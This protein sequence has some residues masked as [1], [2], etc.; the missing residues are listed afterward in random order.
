MS[1]GLGGNMS[2]SHSGKIANESGALTE[3]LRVRA[4]MIITT[5]LRSF[6]DVTLATILLLLLSPVLLAIAIAITLTSPGPV[7]FIQDRIGRDGRLFPFVKFR[8][9]VD[10]AHLQREEVLGT[11][12]EGMLERYQNDPRITPVGKFLRRWS[13]DELPQLLNVAW[14]HMSIVG[15]RPILVEEES[16]LGAN[17]HERHDAKPGLTGLWQISGR[18]ET[19]WEERMDLDIEYVRTSSL[20]GDALIMARTVKVIIK[21]DGAC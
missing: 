10:G 9:M 15:P 8:T 7:F 16:L 20:R 12:D 21:G 18:K 1:D 3:R 6:V 4:P 17:D 19:T 5:P 2:C 11:P 13:V 14:G